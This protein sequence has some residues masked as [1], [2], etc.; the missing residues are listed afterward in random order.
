[1]LAVPLLRA[2]LPHET[3]IA[4]APPDRQ[5]ALQLLL[6]RLDLGLQLGAG[7]PVCGAAGGDGVHGGVFEEADGLFDVVRLDGGGEGDFGDG[8]G[9]PDDGFELAMRGGGQLRMTGGNG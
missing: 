2:K 4:R 9:D 3:L 6:D 1:M 8:F 7:H 5:S